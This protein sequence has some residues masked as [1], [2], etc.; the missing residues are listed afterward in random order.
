[1]YFSFHKRLIL[2]YVP[3]LIVDDAKTLHTRGLWPVAMLA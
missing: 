2:I 1:M 3:L